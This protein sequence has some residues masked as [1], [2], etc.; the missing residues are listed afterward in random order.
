MLFIRVFVC[1]EIHVAETIRN[2][3]IRWDEHNGVNKSSDTATHLARNND[4]EFSWYV[5][6]RAPENTLKR[7]ILEAYFI[8]S[9]VHMTIH[10]WVFGLSDPHIQLPA[11]INV[12]FLKL[13]II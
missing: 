9:I 8:K 12:Q 4:H 3:K 2:Y 1:V 11:P 10:I 6:T 5:L 7:R 13:N